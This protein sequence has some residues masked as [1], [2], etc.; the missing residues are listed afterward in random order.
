LRNRLH[1]DAL[2]KSGVTAHRAAPRDAADV[3]TQI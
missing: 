2:E 3:E 1:S